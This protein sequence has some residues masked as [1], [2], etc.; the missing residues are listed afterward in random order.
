M[1]KIAIGDYV[2]WENPDAPFGPVWI[3]GTLLAIE[4]CNTL[5][6]VDVK[7]CQNSGDGRLATFIVG[8]ATKVGIVA[9]PLQFISRPTPPPTPSGIFTRGIGGGL[10][11]NGIRITYDSLQ[12]GET[13]VRPAPDPLDVKHDGVTLRELL[14]VNERECRDGELDGGPTLPLA[15]AQR[16]AVSA[17]WSA[18]LRRKVAAS[19]ERDRNRVLVDLQDEP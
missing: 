15:P 7:A 18:E 5:A 4:H 19:D 11:F 13:V 10:F 8:R 9:C 12:P 1:S 2:L 14:R 16:A 17:H 6:T 3:T